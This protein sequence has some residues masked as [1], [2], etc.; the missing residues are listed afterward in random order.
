VPRAVATLTVPET[1]TSCVVTPIVALEIE[2]ET[3]PTAAVARIRD[4]IVVLI[5]VPS[6]SGN[7]S[8]EFQVEPPSSDSSTPVGA[9]RVTL[10][11]RSAPVIV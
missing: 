9:V 4:S 2:P 3:L 8:E 7:V 10:A 11:V 1:A 5:S 6:L